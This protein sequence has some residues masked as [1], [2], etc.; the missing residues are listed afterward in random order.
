MIFKNTMEVPT[1][2]LERLLRSAKCRH[3]H[4][5]VVWNDK[6]LIWG[7]DNDDEESTEHLSTIT[8]ILC[9]Y[10]EKGEWI[11]IRTS[12]DGPTI[13][14]GHPAE[15]VND[16]MYIMQTPI[17]GWA[18]V[19]GIPY[20]IPSQIP[21]R[22]TIIMYELDLN[23]WHW[24]KITP[25]GLVPLRGTEE[26]SSWHYRGKIY[27]FGGEC[28]YSEGYV[29]GEMERRYPGYVHFGWGT[30]Q[31]F[32]YNIEENKW[33]W[34]LFKG[35]LPS[36]RRGHTT[37]ISG[38][39]VFLFGGAYHDTLNDLHTLDMVAM[40]W[41]QVHGSS[42]D[43]SGVPSVRKDHSL[44]IISADIA[45]LFGGTC[46][47]KEDSTG[48]FDFLGDCWILDLVKAKSL[49]EESSSIWTRC[50][51]HETP[52]PYDGGRYK[53]AAVLEPYSQRLWII[54]GSYH[55]EDVNAYGE[56]HGTMEYTSEMLVMSFNSATPL[57]LLAKDTVVCCSHRSLGALNSP[58]DDGLWRS[59]AIPEHLWSELE[60]RKASLVEERHTGV[61]IPPGQQEGNGQ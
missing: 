28:Q 9:H 47:G 42:T 27:Y 4:V 57:K 23:S 2:K 22:G 19:G 16:K 56:E 39:T 26:L 15:V 33:E 21:K 12:G 54:G 41:R 25:E 5:A 3:A 53:H 59:L 38:D 49:I 11:R 51:H 37:I 17:T 52:D 43:A 1:S 30:N 34:P 48:E 36:P 45:V 13:Q 60:A 14:Y 29:R 31:F 40:E 18:V 10:G 44:T 55:Y 20:Q 24:T 61:A 46:T 32:C 8:S 35:E 58:Q 7:G 6:T 50:R